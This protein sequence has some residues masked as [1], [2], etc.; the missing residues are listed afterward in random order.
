MSPRSQRLAGALLSGPEGRFVR[1]DVLPRVEEDD[2]AGAL[3][4][5]FATVAQFLTDH[6]L[7]RGVFSSHGT[8][9][10]S[11]FLLDKEALHE[12]CATIQADPS[13]IERV[14]ETDRLRK[15]ITKN[16]QGK[17]Y[18]NILL[19]LLDDE[20]EFGGRIE[21]ASGVRVSCKPFMEVYT[22]IEI[23]YEYAPTNPDKTERSRS[24]MNISPE[25][26]RSIVSHMRESAVGK[27][28]PSDELTTA[29]EAV[30]GEIQRYIDIGQQLPN[31]TDCS[32]AELKL[33]QEKLGITDKAF[34]AQHTDGQ[35]SFSARSK[36][37]KHMIDKLL[38]FWK[39]G[40]G[41]ITKSTGLPGRRSRDFT[42]VSGTTAEFEQYGNCK[43][44]DPDLF[45]P[46]RGASTREAK[47]VCRGCVVRDE[48]LEY[49][50]TN[51]EK[52]GIWGGMSERE[53]R[54]IRRQRA[55]AREAIKTVG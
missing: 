15:I 46:E 43:G 53:R 40:P 16:H 37:V 23:D 18:A 35:S 11:Y 36:Q 50:I 54:R 2:T 29:G 45:F 33:I 5:R 9:G 41:S 21:I 31:L 28:T 26:R 47:E 39:L 1:R 30:L 48:C 10:G 12:T 17:A 20:Y 51:G 13:V 19:L 34:E 55:L 52:F 22:G 14:Q 27:V 25:I 4:Q 44:V 8:R 6:S 3:A 24:F 38:A 32:L 7:L 49:A 42:K